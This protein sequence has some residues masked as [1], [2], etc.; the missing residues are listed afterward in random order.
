SD[1]SH[2]GTHRECGKSF[3]D[4][5]NFISHQRLHSRVRPYKCFDCGKNF[6]RSSH[7]ICHQNIHSGE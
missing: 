4:H 3:S 2:G 6:R 5:S 1:N 7:L